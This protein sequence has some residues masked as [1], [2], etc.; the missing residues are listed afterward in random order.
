MRKGRNIMEERRANMVKRIMIILLSAFMALTVC[1]CSSESTSSTTS[2]TST[3]SSTTSKTSSST[4]S[5]ASAITIAKNKVQSSTSELLS[6]AKASTGSTLKNLT[7]ASSD[8]EYSKSSDRWTVTLY[9]TFSIYDK[10]GNYKSRK[11]L[12]ATIKVD[13]S[14][15]KV[16]SSSFKVS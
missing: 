7:I 16:S 3:T 14:T 8:T 11:N 1:G 13:A 6:K 9:G 10:Y 4:I 12:T 15:G 5:S 2:T